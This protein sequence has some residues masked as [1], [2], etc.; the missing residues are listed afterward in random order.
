MSD[1]KAMPPSSTLA[2]RLKKARAAH[3]DAVAV[4]RLVTHDQARKYLA[5]ANSRAHLH[6]K[7]PCQDVESAM[8]RL[9]ERKRSKAHRQVLRMN[10]SKKARNE[11]E[12]HGVRIPNTVVT[13]MFKAACERLREKNMELG[14]DESVAMSPTKNARALIVGIIQQSFDIVG[15]QLRPWL[16]VFDRQV[17]TPT[18]VVVAARQ[19][20]LVARD[21]APADKKLDWTNVEIG[22]LRDSMFDRTKTEHRSLVSAS[23]ALKEARREERLQKSKAAA[24]DD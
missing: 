3:D 6:T 1:K 14:I 15:Q 24:A 13:R 23:C 10:S 18:M 2:S 17:V 22:P 7:R 4:H 11:I 8:R 20:G 12:T 9:L 5:R 16:A 21:Y 19:S